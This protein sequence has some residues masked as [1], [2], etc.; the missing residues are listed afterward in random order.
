VGAALH[1]QVQ[2]L[3]TR[4]SAFCFLAFFFL[5]SV[6]FFVARMSEIRERR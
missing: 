2:L 1:R 6:R 4:L 3:T 5:F